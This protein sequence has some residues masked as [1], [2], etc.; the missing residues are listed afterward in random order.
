MA[1][2]KE[3]PMAPEIVE[4]LQV[5]LRNKHCRIVLWW[6][7]EQCGIYRNTFSGNS[8][9]YFMEGE[10]NIGLKILNQI[11]AVDAR[12][13]PKLMLEMVAERE[14]QR[15]ARKMAGK[16]TEAHDAGQD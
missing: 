4:A 14:A 5:V 16:K 12:A 15:E 2:K 1:A 10:R 11:A 7:L 3:V 9:T 13:Y 8:A 6:I